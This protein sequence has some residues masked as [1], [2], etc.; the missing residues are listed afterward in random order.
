MLGLTFASK[1]IPI[2][3]IKK[4]SS[5]AGS[6]VMK[7]PGH[8][9]GMYWRSDPTKGKASSS[10]PP[11]W[12]RNG[13]VLRGEVKEFADMPEGSLKWLEVSEYKQ[14]GSAEW[15]K[16]PNCWMQFEQNGALLHAE[17]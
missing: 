14:A 1:S 8:C 3:S 16:T 9:T 6:F 11:D 15:V 12:P 13:A 10:G 4:M 5:S 7:H 2:T 17:K